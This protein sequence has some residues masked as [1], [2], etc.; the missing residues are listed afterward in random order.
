MTDLEK[1]IIVSCPTCY[2]NGGWPLYILSVEY[3]LCLCVST[4]RVIQEIKKRKPKKNRWKILCVTTMTLFVFFKSLFIVIPFPHGYFTDIFLCDQL[5]RYF[6]FLSFQFLALWLGGVVFK[7]FGRDICC[8]IVVP[9]V[10]LGL[11]GSALVGLIVFSSIIAH[12]YDN[13]Q[14]DLSYDYDSATSAAVCVNT[15]VV[16][17]SLLI[18]TSRFMY[19]FIKTPVS[20]L[21]RTKLCIL[22]LVLIFS[23]V[24]FLIRFVWSTCIIFQS[25]VINQDYYIGFAK[26]CFENDN[27]CVSLYVFT[28]VFLSLLDVLPSILLL[29]VFS[30]SSSSSSSQ[31]PTGSHLYSYV[32][33]KKSSK[34]RRVLPRKLYSSSSFSR[35][36]YSPSCDVVQESSTLAQ[37]SAAV[38]THRKGV[39][40]YGEKISPSILASSQPSTSSPGSAG[41]SSTSPLYSPGGTAQ[42]SPTHMPGHVLALPQT[43]AREGET[44]PPDYYDDETIDVYGVL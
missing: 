16:C 36:L 38:N 39:V 24:L 32:V 20:K 10:L 28:L 2:G 29:F 12:D 5:P 40:G 15:G 22:L 7:G 23:F 11:S 6:L 44:P 41:A 18:Y 43:I 27:D 33:S 34:E 26:R 37:I 9:I 13:N 14:L 30:I 17:I 31:Y 8:G 1:I 25:N 19:V 35:S 42:Y 3:I 4:Y 21:I